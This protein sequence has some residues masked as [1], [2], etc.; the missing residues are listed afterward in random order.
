MKCIRCGYESPVQFVKCPRCGTQQNTA[1]NFPPYGS[2]YNNMNYYNNANNANNAGAYNPYPVNN[3]NTA[4]PAKRSGGETAAIVISIIV[5]FL[6]VIA[7][8]VIFV[9]FVAYRASQ[10]VNEYGIDSY[11]DYDSNEYG[12]DEDDIEGFFKDY[13]GSDSIYTSDNPAGLNT[14]ISFKTELYSYSAG[15]VQTEYE[16]TMTAAYRGEAAL[17]MLEGAALPTFDQNESDIYLAE[18][19][20]KI[21]DQDKEAIVPL[22]L[23]YPAAYPSNEISLFSSGYKALTGLD[24]VNQKHLSVKGEDVKTYIAFIVSK[25]DSSPCIKWNLTENK[26]FRSGEEAISDP[27]AVEEGAAIDTDTAAPEDGEAAEE[28]SS[29]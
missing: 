25:E 21:T 9:A 4:L 29:N 16:V 27:S 2:Q 17:K 18:F 10:T 20:V 7:A 5:G 28:S 22:P 13:Y 11:D 23:S 14:P 12:F 19:N 26:V 24:Y 1:Q 8:I 6:S 3:V 15:E